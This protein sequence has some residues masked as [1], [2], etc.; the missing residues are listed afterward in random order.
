MHSE[1]G[2]TKIMNHNDLFIDDITP[3]FSI[4]CVVYKGV[5][6]KR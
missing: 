2:P 3:A 5:S 4:L 1:V 6:I